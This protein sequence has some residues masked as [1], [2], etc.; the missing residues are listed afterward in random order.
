MDKRAEERR[1]KYLLAAV[2]IMA[3]FAYLTAI[4]FFDIPKENIRFADT[5][6]GAI[7]TIVLATVYNFYYGSSEG[8][9]RKT[10]MLDKPID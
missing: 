5:I 8:S 7:I 6:L 3:T 1:F 2:S 10:D 9:N 4:T